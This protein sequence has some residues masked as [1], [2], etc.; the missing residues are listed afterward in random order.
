M[1]KHDNFTINILDESIIYIF[2]HDLSF[3]VF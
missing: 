1:L 3:V 2:F